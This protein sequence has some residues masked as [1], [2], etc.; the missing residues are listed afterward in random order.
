MKRK[1]LY[2]YVRDLKADVIFLQETH[3]TEDKATQWDTEWGHRSFHS[4]GASNA[5]GASILINYRTVKV[6][7][8]AADENGRMV[9]LSIE[10]E[11]ESFTLINVYAPNGDDVAFFTNMTKFAERYENTHMVIA[12]DF[13]TVLDLDLD[14]KGS[15][16]N[17]KPKST[18][19]LLDY[20]EENN[21]CD[22]WRMRNEQ[23]RRYTWFRGSSQASR[24]DYYLCN[25]G[26]A[27]QITTVEIEKVFDSDHS[28]VI[29][30]YINNTIQR[31]KGLWRFNN[32][33]LRNKE[34]VQE[35]QSII[36]TSKLCSL[37]GIE[38]WEHI[39]TNIIQ[40]IQKL[41]RR[42]AYQK[43]EL[44]ENLRS[45]QATLTEEG[46]PEAHDTSK[47]AALDMILPKIGNWRMKK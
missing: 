2:Q 42:G 38:R 39:K 40:E 43:K 5:R 24:I 44:L 22:V 17:V 31:G 18:A 8:W 7:D 10:Y 35:I 23:A 21:L 1:R 32:T 30:E 27:N 28:S 36:A 20:M 37:K 15:N 33:L 4:F 12:G 16:I 25:L 34:A 19:F 3:V 45:L 9:T 13:N 41:S 6:N 26:L 46:P 47:Q 29:M 14:K 11:N